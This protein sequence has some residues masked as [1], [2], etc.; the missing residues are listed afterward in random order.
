MYLSVYGVFGAVS[1]IAI[2]IVT[3]I[4]AVGGLNASTKLHDNMLKSVMRAPMSFFDTNPKGRIVNRFAKDIDLI[5]GSIPL[6][7]SA[8][9]RLGL[10]G[11]GT[12]LVLCT[13]IPLF[14][15]LVIPIIF[16][17][18]IVQKF[19]VA[20]S[21]Q[22]K[23]LESSTRSPIY[24][25]FGEAV[26]GVTTI[27]A[28]GLEE[29]FC[30]DMYNKVDLNSKTMEPNFIAGRWLS[31]RLE[32]LGNLIILFASLLSVLGRNTLE[33]GLVGLC[34]SYA[35]QI[36][37]SL[38]LLIRQTSQIESNMV[39]VERI[40]EYQNQLPKEASWKLD[41]DPSENDWLI[42]GKIAI[43]NLKVRYRENLPMVLKG[44]SLNIDG[45]EKVGIVGRTGSGKS[46]LTLSI[47]R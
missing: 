2:C 14:T 13:I 18:W 25:W 38:N 23:R 15:A 41:T 37:Q 10:A 44:I 21:R 17:Y 46:S 22:F 28:F 34:L 26:S 11:L 12:V 36:T 29:R 40:K 33:P 32:L 5:D 43:N 16:M 1:A 6:T 8:L 20:S 45:G 31:V 47:F 30:M 4:T 19:Y 39:S 3:L 35:M 7:F 24:S 9:L 42:D 27:K